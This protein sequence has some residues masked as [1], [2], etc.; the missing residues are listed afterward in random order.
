MGDYFCGSVCATPVD[1]GSVVQLKF[2]RKSLLYDIG[3]SAYVESD[4]MGDDAEHSR[5]VTADVC[6]NG[7][8]DRVTRVIDVGVNVVRE[9]LYPMTKREA[10]STLIDDRHEDVEEWVIEL[11]VPKDMSGTTLDLLSRLIHEYLVCRALGDWLGVTYPQASAKWLEKAAG[12]EDEIA[13]VRN[14]RR[15]VLTRR[16]WP[17]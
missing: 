5:H 2:L 4:V 1:G 6:E 13:R 3:N 12:L 8:V 15:K 14:H 9:L 16:T 10:V 11:K 7:N 17:W